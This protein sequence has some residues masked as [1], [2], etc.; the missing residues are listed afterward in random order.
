M[1]V[2][3]IGAEGQVGSFLL[4][5]MAGTHA[6]LGTSAEGVANLPRLNICESAQ[7]QACLEQFRPEEVILT[8]ALTHVDKCEIEPELAQAVNVQ[9]TEHVA[10][11]CK[12]V[13]AGLTF[14]STDYIFDGQAGP[15]SET[16]APNPLSVYGRTKLE[17]EQ[18]VASLVER[19]RIIRTMVV[20]SFLPKAKNLYMQVLERLRNREPLSAP[21]DQLVNPTHAVN[22]AQVVRELIEI[23]A[24]GVY[25]VAGTTL[26]PRDEFVRRIVASLGGDPGVVQTQTTADLHQPAARPLKSGLKTGKVRGLLTRESLWDLDTALAY[27]LSQFS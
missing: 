25:H 17:G 8:A 9:G 7:V 27:T 1:K 22:L 16:D 20:Y 4:Q 18:I 15:Y 6:V 12:A 19:H 3:I 11:A 23:G 2:L 14:F 10:K 5:A 24:T 26:L 21:G 13:G